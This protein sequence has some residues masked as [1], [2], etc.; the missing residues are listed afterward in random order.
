MLPIGREGCSRGFG[1]LCRFLGE[2]QGSAAMRT[3]IPPGSETRGEGL[4]KRMNSAFMGGP[5]SRKKRS[6]DL[7]HL[8]SRGLANPLP[9][10]TPHYASTPEPLTRERLCDEWR[11]FRAFPARH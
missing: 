11:Q 4:L 6:S 8:A 9:Q 7:D 2:L 5:L 10:A 1:Q 3:L